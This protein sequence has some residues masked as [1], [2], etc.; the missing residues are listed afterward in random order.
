MTTP[1]KPA[2][3]NPGYGPSDPKNLVTL[4][5]G[6]QVWMTD[7]QHIQYGKGEGPSDAQ[8]AAR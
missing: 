2:N 4:S 8:W 1:M 3:P 5:N 7:A 6:A